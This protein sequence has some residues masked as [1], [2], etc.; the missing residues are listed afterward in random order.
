M[1]FF[2]VAGSWCS[3]ALSGWLIK[4]VTQCVVGKD[5]VGSIDVQAAM[6]V[7]DRESGQS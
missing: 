5:I 7:A 1:V 2:T 4:V 3:A 6:I